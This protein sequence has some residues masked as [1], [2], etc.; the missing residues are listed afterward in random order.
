MITEF[1]ANKIYLL[2]KHKRSYEGTQKC[3]DVK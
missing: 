1:L 2:I 3:L